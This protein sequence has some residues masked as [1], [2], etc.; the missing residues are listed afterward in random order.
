M[1]KLRALALGFLLVVFVTAFAAN[2]PKETVFFYDAWKALEGKPDAI[3]ELVENAILNLL[4]SVTNFESM[5]LRYDISKRFPVDEPITQAEAAAIAARIFGVEED[6]IKRYSLLATTFEN[7]KCKLEVEFE[8]E[9]ASKPVVFDY[10]KLCGYFYFIQEFFRKNAGY[11]LFDNPDPLHAM[12]KGEFL[13]FLVRTFSLYAEAVGFS[14]GQDYVKVANELENRL[15]REYKLDVPNIG[16]IT[17]FEFMF[18]T[19]EHVDDYA[20]NPVEK[21]L[22]PI[23]KLDYF[24]KGNKFAPDDPASRWWAYGLAYYV[25]SRTPYTVY[26]SAFYSLK[27]TKERWPFAASKPSEGAVRELMMV[28]TAPITEAEGKEIVKKPDELKKFYKG[29]ALEQLIGNFM[30]EGSKEDGSVTYKL[31]NEAELYRERAMLYLAM[32]LVADNEDAFKEFLA[33]AKVAPASKLAEFY[34]SRDKAVAKVYE[35]VKEGELFWDY[36]PDGDHFSYKKYF[37]DKAKEYYKKAEE[38]YTLADKFLKDGKK[39]KAKIFAKKMANYTLMSAIFEQASKLDEKN[40]E[41]WLKKINGNALDKALYKYYEDFVPVREVNNTIVY[42]SDEK[43]VN[44]Y[45][46]RLNKQLNARFIP[47]EEIPLHFKTKFESYTVEGFEPLEFYLPKYK[48][49]VDAMI[50]W[51]EEFPKVNKIFLESSKDVTPPSPVEPITGILE[52]KIDDLKAR[53]ILLDNTVVVDKLFDLHRKDPSGGEDIFKYFRDLREKRLAELKDRDDVYIEEGKYFRMSFKTFVK[54]YLSKLPY[55]YWTDNDKEEIDG[56]KGKIEIE[57]PALDAKGSVSNAFFIRPADEE[58][59]DELQNC[60]LRDAPDPKC[61]KDW[62][63]LLVKSFYI[64]L[65][66]SFESTLTIEKIGE[67]VYRIEVETPLGV[68]EKDENKKY[69]KAYIFVKDNIGSIRNFYNIFKDIREK[70]LFDKPFPVADLLWIEKFRDIDKISKKG[71]SLF[72][73]KIGFDPFMKERYPSTIPPSIAHLRLLNYNELVGKFYDEFMAPVEKELV[74]KLKEKYKLE[75][76]SADSIEKLI[77]KIE[78]KDVKKKVYKDVI[79][80]CENSVKPKIKEYIDKTPVKIYIR[81]EA[82][83]SEEGRRVYMSVLGLIDSLSLVLSK[84]DIG[85]MLIDPRVE[86]SLDK[87]YEYSVITKYPVGVVYKDVALSYM[88][89]FDRLNYE[90]K[91]ATIDSIK[92]FVDRYMNAKAELGLSSSGYYKLSYGKYTGKPEV[93]TSE[94][95]G[96]AFLEYWKDVIDK[97]GNTPGET[98]I[99]GKIV[100]KEVGEKIKIKKEDRKEGYI[101]LKKGEIRRFSNRGALYSVSSDGKF[102]TEAG[103]TKDEKMSENTAFML[104]IVAFDPSAVEPDLW[105][106]GNRGKLE[107]L[108]EWTGNDIVEFIEKF[109]SS[110]VSDDRIGVFAG[111]QILTNGDKLDKANIRRIFYDARN[112]LRALQLWK[113]EEEKKTFNYLMLDEIFRIHK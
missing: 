80:F 66:E 103:G 22:M 31:N 2:A 62:Y 73:M 82:T 99:L 23:I 30:K 89:S 86:L 68:K 93:V 113:Y 75:N 24:T 56:G 94:D 67:D 79:E 14:R 47:D 109:D 36:K 106:E 11:T 53:F 60:A 90:R 71:K 107:R 96:E 59:K 43:V 10:S 84:V 51:P 25:F 87:E 102:Y 33:L 28:Y 34:D 83:G 42:K 70:I 20:S 16:Y 35:E 40:V 12:T 46:D 92:E 13:K 61:S 110:A 17:T 69:H 101:G 5:D 108:Y 72:E 52:G 105:D 21:V 81:Q 55:W 38:Y 64:S 27:D 41:K 9:K 19:K 77:E 15:K 85:K 112:T 76:I 97:L 32:A 57:A 50:T 26:D 6:I 8:K 39:D 29:K 3:K 45:K 44:I 88:P 4:D 100:V 111:F 95:T 58:F 18:L 48:K 63:N 104:N 37:E 91:V 54:E 7:L 74:Q 49:L 1:K 65:G 78:N 98:P